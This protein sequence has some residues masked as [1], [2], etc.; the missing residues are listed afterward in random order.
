MRN[1]HCWKEGPDVHV[2][3]CGSR[4]HC[5][6]RKESILG[7][8]S[9]NGKKWV[10]FVLSCLLRQGLSEYPWLSWN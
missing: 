8:S 3:D 9:W 4:G 6:V 2:A 1:G 7:V 5:G 10:F